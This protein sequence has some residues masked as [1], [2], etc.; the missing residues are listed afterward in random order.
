MTMLTDYALGALAGLLSAL[1]MR[2]ARRERR[3]SVALWGAGFA[4]L[5]LAALAA[6]AYHGFPDALGPRL[7][8]GLWSF[9][10]WTMGSA[11]FFMF[12]GAILA[13]S[14]GAWR[15][16][17]LAAAL[18]KLAAFA[19]LAAGR[20]EYAFVLLDYGSAQVAILV[21]A[22]FAWHRERAS[23]A[24]WL[25]AGVGVSAVGAAVQHYGL[26][27]HEQFNHNDLYH[28]I[29]ML[30][31]YFLFRGGVSFPPPAPEGSAAPG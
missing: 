16:L 7:C 2:T 3:R 12:S 8:A 23:C 21:L 18:V 17:L 26:A 27:P 31:L 14:T 19:I 22:A 29:Q 6:G 5:A 30:G 25:A 13:L 15:T 20:D 11:S 4:G 24:P 1:L 28:V 10:S 9:V